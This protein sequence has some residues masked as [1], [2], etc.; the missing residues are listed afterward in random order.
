[1]QIDQRLIQQLLQTNKMQDSQMSLLKLMKP[2]NTFKGHLIEVKQNN[3]ILQL[4]NGQ[5]IKARLASPLSLAKGESMSFL[6]TANKDGQIVIKPE[7]LISQ[8]SPVIEAALKA[9]G[10]EMTQKNIQLVKSLMNEQLPIDKGSLLKYSTMLKIP[11]TTPERLNFLAKSDIPIKKEY[12]Q[13]LNALLDGG[14]TLTKGLNH[15]SKGL[16]AGQGEKIIDEALRELEVLLEPKD[17]T[18]KIQGEQKPIV[19]LLHNAFKID[20]NN[21]NSLKDTAQ[22]FKQLDKSMKVLSSKLEQTKTDT[23]PQVIAIKEN[24]EVVK[25]QVELL[26]HLNNT[27]E[28]IH[29]P[30]QFSNGMFGGNLYIVDEKDNSKGSESSRPKTAILSLDLAYLGTIEAYVAV[31]KE[32]QVWCDLRLENPDIRARVKRQLDKLG[33]KINGVGYKVTSLKVSP[34]VEPYEP[35]TPYHNE[36]KTMEQYSFDQ[37]V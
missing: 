1:M 25:N 9:A 11:G 5:H 28:V 22:F 7:T 35:I 23:T 17:M 18:T 29:L 19:K 10:V 24:V 15:I 31:T 32:K 36:E 21:L 8:P 3:V 33:R 30:L 16:I 34:L 13:G 6:V 2:G 12:I 14:E 26:Q 20:I 27:M 37:K 4:L